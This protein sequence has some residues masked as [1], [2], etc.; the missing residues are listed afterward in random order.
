MATLF[1]S[2][3]PQQKVEISQVMGNLYVIIT[4]YH[5]MKGKI[6]IALFHSEYDY[7]SLAKPLQA[8]SINIIQNRSVV[9]F[10][11]LVPGDYAVKVYH[12]ENND[13]KLNTNFI[14]KPTEVYGF[15]NNVRGTFGPASWSA[16]KFKF[17][18]AT[19]SIRIE[20]K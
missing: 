10:A 11:N 16:A 7:Q 12:D 15:S 4:G 8:D 5:S 17:T 2:A 19:D 14:G 13:G 3:F 1:H 20:L 6:R 18:A 9:V